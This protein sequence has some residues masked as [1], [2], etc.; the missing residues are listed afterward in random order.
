MGRLRQE[1][2]ITR[3]KTPVQKGTITLYHNAGT[4]C[5]ATP[6]H[7]R[8]RP[9]H[10]RG[11]NGVGRW[12]SPEHP[13]SR[14]MPEDRRRRKPQARSKRNAPPTMGAC[15]STHGHQQ[16]I[17]HTQPFPLR[18][19]LKT[20][21]GRAVGCGDGQTRATLKGGSASRGHHAP[22]ESLTAI[23]W[24]RRDVEKQC[25]T[26][27]TPRCVKGKIAEGLGSDDF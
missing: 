11:F 18:H 13:G 21:K 16:A 10:P 6:Q 2:P 1:E 26:H 9:G 15:S 12:P 27:H 20:L 5:H 25:G 8:F 14:A 23:L 17:K 24:M 7:L 4:S 22:E 19:A 3:I